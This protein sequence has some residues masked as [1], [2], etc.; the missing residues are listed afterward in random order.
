MIDTVTKC[1]ERDFDEDV[2]YLESL[3]GQIQIL[4]DLGVTMDQGIEASSV[5]DR[6]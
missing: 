3:G 6:T 4:K 1:Q 2:S 5:G